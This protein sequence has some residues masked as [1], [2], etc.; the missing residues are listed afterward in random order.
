MRDSWSGVHL[1]EPAGL[2]TAGGAFPMRVFRWF[3]SLL[4]DCRFAAR[5]SARDIAFTS[6]AVLTIALGIGGNSAVFSLLKAIVLHPLPYVRPERLVWLSEAQLKSEESV[7]WLD[8]LDIRR[9]SKRLR[10]IAAIRETLFITNGAGNAERLPGADVSANF[11]PVLGIAPVLGRT[12]LDSDNQPGATP[13]V[14]I[15]HSLWLRTF[16]GDP[17]I[18]GKSVTLNWREYTVA[19][20]LP[21]DFRYVHAL[22]VFAP[23]MLVARELGSRSAHP[24]L[25]VLGRMSPEADI[26]QVRAEMSNISALLARRYPESDRNQ[27]IKVQPLSE[28]FT[29]SLDQPLFLLTGAVGFVLLIACANLANLLLARSEVRRKEMAVRAAIGA[30]RARIATQVIAES[31]Y[32]SLLGSAAG[33]LLAI[34]GLKLVRFVIPEYVWQLT[35]VHIDFAVLLFTL[36]TAVITAVLF[37]GIPARHLSQIDVASSLKTHTRGMT[38][39]KPG[40]NVRSTLV[41]TEIGLALV[42]TAGAGMALQSLERL[43]HTRLGFRPDHILTV[44]INPPPQYSTDKKILALYGG[45]RASIGTLP[46]VAVVGMVQCLPLRDGACWSSPVAFEGRPATRNRPSVDFNVAD[47]GYF[48]TMGIPLKR[49]RLFDTRDTLASRPVVLINETMARRFWP[50]EDPVGRKL[51]EQ[52]ATSESDALTVV[53]VVGDTKYRSLEGELR[54]Q[55]F[56]PA[57]Q[58]I[59]GMTLV[60]RTRV[61]PLGISQAVRRV[62]REL[63]PAIPVHDIATMA[64]V[65]WES[66][67]ARRFPA[68]VLIIFALV[69]LTLASVGIYGIMGYAVAQRRQ[70]IGIRSALGAVPNDLMGLMVREFATLTLPGVG[71]GLIATVSLAAIL[72]SYLYGATVSDVYVLAGAVLMVVLFSAVAAYLP[73]RRAATLDPMTV[74]RG[75]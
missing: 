50:G 54:P 38:G 46:G 4:Q 25:G 5:L 55:V 22:D 71:L 31:L 58:V 34:L 66:T 59:T 19:G 36:V 49:G 51:R 40:R 75:G 27:R 13:V 48:A 30:S 14:L 26:A 53:G 57:A 67:A 45:L 6:V 18:A 35:G 68:A 74:L 52:Y 43:N 16:H 41:N 2:D 3:E 15:S 33:L 65:L 8:Y 37:G 32:L 12:L 29:G 70:E 21:A 39:G 44:P 17:N 56:Y 69:A 64:L 73:A 60:I 10:D 1:D 62:I 23:I 28:A 61:E 9:Q 72:R 11:F 47:A 24:P 63:E 42:L 7:S 20:V